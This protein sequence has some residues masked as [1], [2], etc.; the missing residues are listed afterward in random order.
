MTKRQQTS[1][2]LAAVFVAVLC[3]LAVLAAAASAATINSLTVS[4][5]PANP[6]FT[7]TGSG[8]TVPVPNPKA[9]PS[10]QALCPLAI[11]GNAGLDYGTGL[12]LVGWDGQT[13]G[14]NAQLYAAGRYRP[15]LNELDCIGLVVLSHTP[16][17][18]RFT[19]GHAY[20]QYYRAKPRLLR[21][22]DVVE[23]VIGGAPYAAVVRFH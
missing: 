6:V 16:T 3:G 18:V 7:V 19:F 11:S 22:G 12:Y 21:N 1:I 13:G 4:G 9:S 10:K 5:T 8:L 23:V 20:V 2:R 17:R 15:T 14:T